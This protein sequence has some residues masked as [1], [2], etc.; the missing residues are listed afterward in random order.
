MMRGMASPKTSDEKRVKHEGENK[1]EEDKR[2]I[3]IEWPLDK[4]LEEL[5]RELRKYD[6]DWVSIELKP[7][8]EPKLVVEIDVK[9]KEAV[10]RA[11][12]FIHKEPWYEVISWW[13]A[14]YREKYGG[15]ERM[16]KE[17]T[18]YFR[19]VIEKLEKEVK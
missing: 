16:M 6:V 8:K 15:I 14:E 1:H 13:I 11:P 5:E 19:K 4:P 12:E 17:M 18:E 7:I 3:R 2:T 10:I 9:D